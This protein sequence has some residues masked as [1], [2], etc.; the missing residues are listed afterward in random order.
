MKCPF[1]AEAVA[2]EAIV[3]RTCR[4]DIS[5]PRPLMEQNRTLQAK[6]EALEAEIA[7]LRAETARPGRPSGA[8]P[9]VDPRQLLV[10]YVLI[11]TALLVAV[12]FVLV[13]VLDENLLYLRIA[14]AVLPMIFG[15]ALQTAGPPRWRITIGL[16]CLVAVASALGMSLVMYAAY[17]MPVWPRQPIEQRELL[18]YAVS[19]AL[20]YILGALLAAKVLPGKEAGLL[21]AFMAANMRRPGKPLEQ[22][23][24]QWEKI[25]R[26][27]VSLITA[28]GMIYT[29]FRRFLT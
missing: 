8:I 10:P 27:A 15:Y 9:A 4:R 26:F 21:A 3:C 20:A 14:T 11:P 1:C 22:H 28:A 17:R 6:V 25:A 2:D 5:I 18:E 24:E 29:G 19:M 23:M 12:H 16:A 13:V 7:A